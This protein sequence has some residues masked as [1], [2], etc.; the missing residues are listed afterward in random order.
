MC[1]GFRLAAELVALSQTNAIDSA[2]ES[3]LALGLIRFA[4]LRI[5]DITV[6]LADTTSAACDPPESG[7]IY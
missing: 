2:R 1:L 5:C 6:Q 7:D 3:A 4:S